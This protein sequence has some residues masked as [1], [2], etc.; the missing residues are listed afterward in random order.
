VSSGF[1]PYCSFSLT[2]LPIPKTRKKSIEGK[3]REMEDKYD[4]NTL[5]MYRK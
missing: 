2:T 1:S 4:Q 3:K 5:Y